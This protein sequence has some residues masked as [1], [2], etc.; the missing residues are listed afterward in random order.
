MGV[1]KKKKRIKT[2][3]ELKEVR[4]ELMGDIRLRLE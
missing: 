4:S 1:K 2:R 3:I